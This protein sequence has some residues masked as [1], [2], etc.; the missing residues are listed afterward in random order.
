MLINVHF[1]M[2]KKNPNPV[3]EDELRKDAYSMIPIMKGLQDDFSEDDV[4]SA[5]NF[6]QE[7]YV[8]FPRHEIVKVSGLQLPVNKRNFRKQ[9]LH[10]KLARANRDILQLEDNKVWY[11]NSPHIGRKAKEDIV[12][13]WRKNNPDGKKIDCHR[14]TGLSRVTIDKWWNS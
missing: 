10:L 5:L 11:D 2:K 1:T 8:N 14:D 4:E 3:T 6:F 7:C 13:E 9:K 12:L